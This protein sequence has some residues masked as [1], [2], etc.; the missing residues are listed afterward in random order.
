MGTFRLPLAPRFTLLVVLLLPAPP[1][2]AQTEK[3]ADPPPAERPESKDRLFLGRYSQRV[4]IDVGSGYARMLQPILSEAGPSWLVNSAVRSGSD[5]TRPVAL[6]YEDP[7]YNRAPTR[8]WGVEYSWK[9]RL[10]VGYQRRRTQT[11]FTRDSGSSQNFFQAPTSLYTWSL[12]E[13]LRVLKYDLTQTQVDVGYY[14]PITSRVRLG[15][16]LQY[17]IY[18]ETD[19]ITLGSYMLRSLT[20]TTN[21]GL[22]VWSPMGDVRFHSVMRGLYPGAGLKW[23]AMPWLQV[24]YRLYMV[25]RKGDFTLQ[26]PQVMQSQTSGGAE[27]YALLFPVYAGSLVE[28]GMKHQ[29]EAVFV[30]CRFQ[31]AVGLLKEDVKRTYSSYA[32]Q[33]IGD[34]TDVSLKFGTIGLGE[35]SASFAG[36]AL[37]IYLRL[38][39]SLH[40]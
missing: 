34:A 15:P 30:R 21:P 2:L 16:V 19:T 8:R 13:G 33:T 11:E 17:E 7:A 28:K 26:G 25:S 10:D 5:P 3:P 24:N 22:R 29:V 36:H 20:A 12:F 1:L 27:S 39:T 18:D 32:G 31:L 6:P 37:E 4:R 23:Y 40:F 14:H 35:Q 38:G 9:D